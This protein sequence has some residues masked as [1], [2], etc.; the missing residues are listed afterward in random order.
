MKV[1]EDRVETLADNIVFS[2][3]NFAKWSTADTFNISIGQG[4]NQYTHKWIIVRNTYKKKKQQPC[5]NFFT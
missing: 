5:N 4:E 2:Y 3:L 1:K